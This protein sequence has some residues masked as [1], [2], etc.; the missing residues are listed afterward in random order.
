M[1]D[2]GWPEL[3]VILVVALV[4]IGP[5]DLPRALHTVGKW[6]RKARMMAREFQ[7]SVDEMVRQAE[8]EDLKKQVE[9]ARSFNVK[10][11]ITQAVD[12]DGGL[13]DAFTI[14]D[15]LED[16]E[17]MRPAPQPAT[18]QPAAAAQPAT[19]QQSTAQP[20]AIAAPAAQPVMTPVAPAAE[21][22][23]VAAPA[24][25]AEKRG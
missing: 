6:V 11:Q 15:S 13:K 19:T 8:L 20:A 17:V 18:A 12:P 5:K 21:P 2:I 4:V 14:E 7:G 9:Q 24:A 3:A 25:P 1:F 22:A 16:V 10:D 23:P